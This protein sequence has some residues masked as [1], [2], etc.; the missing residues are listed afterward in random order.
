[1]IKIIETEISQKIE[2]DIPKGYIYD[3]ERKPVLD[4]FNNELKIPIKKV[5]TELEKK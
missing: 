5:Y 1:M 2:V 4:D 3:D